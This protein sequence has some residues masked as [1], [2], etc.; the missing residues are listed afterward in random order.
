[1]KQR[2]EFYLKKSKAFTFLSAAGT[3]LYFPSSSLNA[4]KIKFNVT[5][6]KI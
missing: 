4:L 3:T 6:I 1:M 2:W 5:E